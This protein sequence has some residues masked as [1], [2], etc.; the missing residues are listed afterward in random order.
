MGSITPFAKPAQGRK[1]RA[2]IF[3]AKKH[4][5]GELFSI[6]LPYFSIFD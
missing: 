6:Q 2:I 5:T 3:K 4:I 1:N